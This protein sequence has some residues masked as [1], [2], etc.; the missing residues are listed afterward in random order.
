[1][2]FFI[3]SFFKT[4]E[5]F[6]LIPPHYETA[7]NAYGNW[8]LTGR[9]INLKKSIRLTSNLPDQEGTICS[10]IP[11]MFQDWSIEVELA[12][13]GGEVG[14]SFIAFFFSQSFCLED[15]DNLDGVAI[16]INT[17]KTDATGYSPVHIVNDLNIEKFENIEPS[18]KV[19]IRSDS[20]FPRILKFTRMGQS[21]RIES[22]IK[23]DEYQVLETK[24]I[25]IPDRV[26]FTIAAFTSDT[27]TD[28]H[29]IISIRLIQLSE[30]T[31]SPDSKIDYADKNLVALEKSKFIRKEMKEK[32]REKL[33]TVKSIIEK[34]G[35]STELNGQMTDEEFKK[36]FALIDELIN[37]SSTTIS[38][39]DFATYFETYVKEVIRVSQN[40]LKH[41]ADQL[42]EV[43]KEITGL[44]DY[45]KTKMLD[46]NSEAFESKKWLERELIT[47][48]TKMR[49]Q[50][51]DFDMNLVKKGLKMEAEVD[52]SLIPL[53]LLVICCIEF[54]CYLIFFFIRRSQTKRFK[55]AD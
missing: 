19:Q 23:D 11:T 25:N 33:P 32:R 40:K 12:A 41:S 43:S 5:D 47:E 39:D 20:Y 49:S 28:I 2:I 13:Y 16:L 7:S 27:N 51:G 53:I 44:W 35:N 8:T 45:L 38:F 34:M 6:N 24:E 1:M 46:L 52:D 37:R 31:D 9:A 50:K 21:F 36:S 10:L 55:K 22:I 3:L 54:V 17:G 18:G 15:Q 42:D 30:T 48:I 4:N 26:Y 29:D 14:G